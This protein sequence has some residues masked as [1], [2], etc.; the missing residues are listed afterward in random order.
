MTTL[1]EIL[2]GTK[3]IFDKYRSETIY[4]GI[5]WICIS[6]AG[7]GIQVRLCRHHNFETYFL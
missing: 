6:F 1:D 7:F 5:V 2:T 4:L 3:L